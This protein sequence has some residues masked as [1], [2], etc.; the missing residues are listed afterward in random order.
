MVGNTANK[1]MVGKDVNRGVNRH[2]VENVLIGVLIGLLLS[3]S[4]CELASVIDI[5]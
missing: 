2:F 5:V 3:L 4:K 1:G